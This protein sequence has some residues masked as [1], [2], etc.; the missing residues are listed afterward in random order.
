MKRSTNAELKEERFKR[1]ATDRAH[2][3]I[4]AYRVLGNCTNK[5]NYE[6]SKEQIDSMFNVLD[7]TLKDLKQKFLLE[8]EPEKRVFFK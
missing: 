6:Y 7:K 8:L 1:V 3:I 4:N 5:K 2:R